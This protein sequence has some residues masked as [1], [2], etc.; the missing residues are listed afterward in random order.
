LLGLLADAACGPNDPLP[1]LALADYLT[2]LGPGP[3]RRGELP[4]W[5]QRAWLRS[6]RGEDAGPYGGVD[7]E[8]IILLDLE[9]WFRRTAAPRA[10][11][12]DHAGATEVG[13]LPGF[14]SE[15]YGPLEVARGQARLLAAKARC[16]GVA[17][18]EGRW[19]RDVRRVLLL[20]TPRQLPRAF[21]SR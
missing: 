15:P 3:V 14:A 21:R 10:W 13:G 7:V 17:L 6:R 11:Y 20:P 2:E 9:D 4:R 12:L 5:L 18:P 1:Q 19:N 8:G 16:V